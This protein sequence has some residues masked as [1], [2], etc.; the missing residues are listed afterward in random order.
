MSDDVVTLATF[1]TPAEAQIAKNML[2]E[3]GIKAMIADEETVGMAWVIGNAVGGVKLL[4]LESQWMQARVA[5]AHHQEHLEEE[6]DGAESPEDYGDDSPEDIEEQI[7]AKPLQNAIADR[8]IVEKPM[9][10]AAEPGLDEPEP[11]IVSEGEDLAARAFR[12]SLFGIVLLFPP[13]FHMYSA[14]LLIKL[15]RWDGE[16][17]D[18]AT[19]K[20][21]IAMIIDAIVLGI[22]FFVLVILL[23]LLQ[24]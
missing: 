11:I 17:S 16:L 23:N 14:W 19:T 2:E 1:N 10:M 4:V 24:V 9:R 3:Q 21:L 7:T 22:T 8:P 20:M 18:I 12:A 15:F 13:V 6:G 5:L